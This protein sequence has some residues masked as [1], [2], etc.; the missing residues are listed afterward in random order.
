MCWAGR[1]RNMWLTWLLDWSL[2]GG[3]AVQKAHC[4]YIIRSSR[5]VT[6]RTVKYFETS[7]L[8]YPKWRRDDSRVCRHRLIIRKVLFFNRAM[9]FSSKNAAG[10]G[11]DVISYCL[12][13]AKMVRV[14]LEGCSWEIGNGKLSRDLHPSVHM[15]KWERWTSVTASRSLRLHSSLVTQGHA[16]TLTSADKRLISPNDY[17]SFSFCLRFLSLSSPNLTQSMCSQ[18]KDLHHMCKGSTHLFS[19]TMAQPNFLCI[20]YWDCQITW[21][22]GPFEAK[23]KSWQSW[24]KENKAILP[25]QRTSSK[26]KRLSSIQMVPEAFSFLTSMMNTFITR[27]RLVNL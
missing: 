20:E 8:P 11:L 3:A 7:C 1:F 27:E 26:L 25:R 24:V 9:A 16:Q 2:K 23:P 18:G 19:L 5:E 17:S 6:E 22:L 21:L 15:N 13:R 10:K 4:N 12:N 14:D